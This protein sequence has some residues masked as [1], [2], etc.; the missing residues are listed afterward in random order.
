[1]APEHLKFMGGVCGCVMVPSGWRSTRAHL[2]VLWRLFTCWRRVG[3]FLLLIVLVLFQA[4]GCRCVDD[5]FGASRKGACLTGGVILSMLTPVHGFPCDD[6]R[7][8][9]Y[10]AAMKVLGCL[11]IVSFAERVLYTRA[12]YRLQLKELLELQ[13]LLPG[14]AS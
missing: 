3:F 2:L 14:D 1:M 8:A 13:H 11:C 4:P 7:N 10:A 12:Q 9:D 6:S 5:F